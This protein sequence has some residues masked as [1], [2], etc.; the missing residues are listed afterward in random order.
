MQYDESLI[1]CLSL[2]NTLATGG[3]HQTQPDAHPYLP[4]PSLGATTGPSP[5]LTGGTDS[6]IQHKRMRRRQNRQNKVINSH[7]F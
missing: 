2:F 1:V 5:R 6:N 7:Y 3:P 4:K